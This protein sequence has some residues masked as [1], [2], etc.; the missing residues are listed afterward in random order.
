[1]QTFLKK[2]IELKALKEGHFKLKSGKT[3][4]YFFDISAFF[5]SNSLSYLASCYVD[6][7]LKQDL[8]FNLIF[9]PAYKGIPLATAV[10]L[11]YEE[12]TGKTIPVAFDRKEEKDHGEGGN[13]IG[14]LDNKD[15]LIIDDV[16]TAGTA[17]KNSISVLTK[18][19]GNFVAAF[20]ALDREEKIEDITYKQF[21]KDEGI[22]IFSIAKISD[23]K[24]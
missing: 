24:N 22:N 19:R 12:K 6:E 1:M 14:N 21:L 13:I 20:V 5:D 8:D 11:S 2:A 18:H 10:A 9:G 17:I 23:L 7:I 4:N 15:V 16:L 3:S